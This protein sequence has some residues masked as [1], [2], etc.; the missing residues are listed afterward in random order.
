[1][2]LGLLLLLTLGGCD[3]VL[4]PFSECDP[5]AGVVFEGRPDLTTP[6]AV[7]SGEP[8]LVTV[9]ALPRVSGVGTV[10][11]VSQVERLRV[12]APVQDTLQF[13]A[14]SRGGTRPARVA[15]VAGQR[16]ESVWTLA[17]DNLPDVSLLNSGLG[18][19]VRMDSVRLPDGRLVDLFSDEGLRHVGSDFDNV[20]DRASAAVRLVRVTGG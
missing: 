3:A 14:G 11:L 12:F 10:A 13:G 19:E 20:V 9:R 2:R 16:L 8:F 6:A 17:A 1:M 7:R 4:C 15:F 18:A 5:P